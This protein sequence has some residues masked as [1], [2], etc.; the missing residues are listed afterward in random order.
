MKRSLS[1]L[2]LASLLILAGCG[3]AADSDDETGARP[4]A[5]IPQI[6]DLTGD[7]LQSNSESEEAFMSATIVED[8]I[9]VDWTM[10][11][12][13]D[14][15]IFDDD[16]DGLVS[17]VYW[18]GSFTAPTD[19]T[20]SY[21]WTSQADA[22]V[23]DTALLGSMDDS[24]DFAYEDGVLSFTVTIQGESTEAELEQDPFG[25]AEVAPVDEEETSTADIEPLPFNDNG[26]LGGD[27]SP[28]VGVG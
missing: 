23:L 7:W 14:I 17:F 12:T 20:E 22:S 11:A 19:A 15:S 27:A 9:S 18:A 5:D 21:T 16:G 8:T 10:P 28:D 24:K 1:L 25:T 4:E 13:D 6:P 2:A 3:G 26:W